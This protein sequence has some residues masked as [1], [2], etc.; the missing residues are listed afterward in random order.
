MNSLID[1]YIDSLNIPLKPTVSSYYVVGIECYSEPNIYCSRYEDYILEL[2]IWVTL[3][4]ID[5]IYWMLLYQVILYK[6]IFS[7]LMLKKSMYCYY[8][9]V[10]E[11]KAKE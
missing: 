5:N 8:P 4:I 10:I 6:P 1:S 2:Q 3:K 9:C 7:Y 11:E